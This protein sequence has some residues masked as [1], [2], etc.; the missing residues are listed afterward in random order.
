MERHITAGLQAKDRQC[1]TQGIRFPL[2]E[3]PVTGAE[4]NSGRRRRQ[5][6]WLTYF[7]AQEKKPEKPQY[8][9]R[10]STSDPLSGDHPDANMASYGKGRKSDI[11]A[12]SSGGRNPKLVRSRWSDR[13][14][15]VVRHPQ[16]RVTVDVYAQAQDAAAAFNWANLPLLP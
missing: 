8:D 16:L 7:R 12:D 11:P 15:P 3:N 14:F 13:T 5:N 9:S 1:L 2:F 10:D 6:S 4:G